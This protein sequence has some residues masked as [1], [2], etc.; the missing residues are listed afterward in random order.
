MVGAIKGVVQNRRRDYEP[1]SM[2]DRLGPFHLLD[3][4]R[5]ASHGRRESKLE[6]SLVLTKLNFSQA[7]HTASPI[8]GVITG[9]QPSQSAL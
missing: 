7:F 2:K 1:G 6:A 4:A 9:L 8:C 5:C 3:L